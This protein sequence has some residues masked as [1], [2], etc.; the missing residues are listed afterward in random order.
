M[1]KRFLF[2]F[3]CILSLCI[4]AGCSEEKSRE[5]EQAIDE[6]VPTENADITDELEPTEEAVITVTEEP[7]QTEKPTAT[8]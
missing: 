5:V 7:A 2:L 6:P 8:P 1:K 4:F 3:I